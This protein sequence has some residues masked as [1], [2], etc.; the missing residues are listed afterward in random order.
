MGMKRIIVAGAGERGRVWLGVLADDPR[1]EVA[2]VVDPDP[3]ALELA[4]T[5]PRS[6]CWRTFK[7]LKTA[8]QEVPADAVLVATPMLKH[9]GHVKESLEAGRHV[10]VEKPFVT[11][12]DQAEELVELAEEKGLVLAVAQQFR[13]FP[14]Y[15]TLNRFLSEGRIGRLVT[16]MVSFHRDRPVR[17]YGVDEPYPVLFIQAIHYLDTLRHLLETEPKAVHAIGLRPPWSPYR[18]PPVMEITLLY[19]DMAAHISASHIAKGCQTPYEGVWRIAGEKGDLW[20]EPEPSGSLRVVVS[21]K[22]GEEAVFVPRGVKGE[23][24]RR[25]LQEFA[26][27]IEGGPP[28]S[29][30]VRDNLRTLEILFAAIESCRRGQV[31]EI[32]GLATR[33]GPEKEGS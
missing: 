20:L 31:V 3:R 29:T 14:A 23:P 17:A 25:L 15:Q 30:D 11:E 13:Y 1:W 16:V 7:E 10:L 19:E 2:A 18:N 33:K 6:G 9:Y 24:E 22:A 28:P 8:V 4:N 32:Q 21:Q 27:A 5:L 12:P 26:R